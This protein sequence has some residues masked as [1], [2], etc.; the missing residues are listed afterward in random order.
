MA[1]YDQ[2]RDRVRHDRIQ[3][4]RNAIEHAHRARRARGGR[5]VSPLRVARPRTT[6]RSRRSL[7][8]ADVHDRRRQDDQERQRRLR[9]V[10]QAQRRGRQRDLRP[11]FLHRHVACGGQVQAD[12]RGARLLGSDHRRGPADRHRQ[13]FRHQRRRARQSQHQ[14]SERHDDRVRRAINPDTGKPYGMSF[15]GRVVPRLGARAQGA[16][17]FARREKAAGGRRR[18]RRLDP[19]DGMGARCIRISSSASSTSSVR[20]STSRRTSSRCSTS[21]RLPIRLDPKW[22]NGDYYG[23]RRA[24]STASRRRS[25]SSRSRARAGW[26]EKTFGYKWADAGEESGG[27]DGQC[28]RDRG[29]DRTRPAPRARKTTDANSLIYTAKANQLYNLGDEVKG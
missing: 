22:N 4:D 29:H 6:A 1:R 5:S 8:A 25:R 15:P 26:A 12:R 23:K 7:H 27:G 9:N 18:V 16:R 10:R 19:G 21:G 24:A 13:V 17:R 20:A 11:A 14:G 2:R 28:V 3:G